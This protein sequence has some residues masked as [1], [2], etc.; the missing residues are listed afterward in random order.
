MDDDASSASDDGNVA[1]ALD[2]LEHVL[3]DDDFKFRRARTFVARQVRKA[4]RRREVAAAAE[5]AAQEQAGM[6][7][8]FGRYTGS[9][10]SIEKINEVFFQ[11]RMKQSLSESAL[12]TGIGRAMAFRVR[13][14]IS[15]RYQK[16]WQAAAR[17]A[18]A[19]LSQR[20]PDGVT[21]FSVKYKW[22]ETEQT[23]SVPPPSE[24]QI[25]QELASE[26][27]L[28]HVRHLRKSPR[29]VHVMTCG[30]WVGVDTPPQVCIVPPAQLARTTAECLWS[31]LKAHI[32]WGPWATLPLQEEAAWVVLTFT[33]D[34][35]SSNIRLYNQARMAAHAAREQAITHFAACKLH[36]LQ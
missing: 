1:L 15:F 32:P 24:V 31:V 27:G 36:T 20:P 18:I 7:A 11:K 2:R 28:S 6:L 9:A 19:A 8:T 3:D 26:L 14:A 29:K 34:E 4:F 10:L 17:A 25:S 35:A 16:H 33:A 22:D 23:L 12:I 21:V 13:A 30:V 5:A